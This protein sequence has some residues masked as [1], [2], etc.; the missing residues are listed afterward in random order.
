MDLLAA[1][2]RTFGHIVPG[3]VMA[4]GSG[5]RRRRRYIG[6]RIAG[7]PLLSSKNEPDSSRAHSRG[8]RSASAVRAEFPMDQETADRALFLALR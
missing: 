5:R 6:R 4:A 3:A 7:R 2:H 1:L 8:I